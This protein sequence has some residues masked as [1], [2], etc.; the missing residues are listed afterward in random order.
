[1]CLVTAN[2]GFSVSKKGS[3]RSTSSNRVRRSISTIT[4]L[5]QHDIS[6]GTLNISAQPARRLIGFQL[7][8]VRPLPR[9]SIH[10]TNICRHR[11]VDERH[12]LGVP[13]LGRRCVVVRPADNQVTV[14]APV[15]GPGTAMD[16]GHPPDAGG[17][18]LRDGVRR[19]MLDITRKITK[20][21]RLVC[22]PN[23]QSAE[24]AM[25]MRPDT[26]ERGQRPR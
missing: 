2:P 26:K 7:R 6:L 25:I 14:N 10:Q 11:S 5:Y 8:R 4:C 13:A 17:P 1:V 21:V 20:V 22:E 3:S 12:V 24:F 19:A 15:W 9:L 23:R 18:R 16:A